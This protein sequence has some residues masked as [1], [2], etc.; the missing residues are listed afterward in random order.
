MGFVTMALFWRQW[1]REAISA[2]KVK[3]IRCALCWSED[4]ARLAKEH[5]NANMI[6]LGERQ[7]TKEMAIKIV[8]IWLNSSFEAWKT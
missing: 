2:N 3:N 6:S 5:N 1:K 4:T 8:D 7:I